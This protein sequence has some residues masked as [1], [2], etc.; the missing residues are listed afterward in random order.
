VAFHGDAFTFRPTHTRVKYFA[1]TQ[2]KR[3]IRQL[4][5]VVLRY[6]YL[7]TDCFSSAPTRSHLCAME[8]YLL[9]LLLHFIFNR[10]QRPLN[11]PTVYIYI[12]IYIRNMFS[13]QTRPA[14]RIGKS[15]PCVQTKRNKWPGIGFGITVQKV[16]H[17]RHPVAYSINSVLGDGPEVAYYL[18][19]PCFSSTFFIFLILC[20][21]KNQSAKT[22]FSNLIRL[23]FLLS[24]LLLNICVS[25]F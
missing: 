5:N 21:K 9:L 24:L 18:P 10:G 14:Q 17:M 7:L 11:A 3:A 20:D 12:Y 8:R 1:G 16:Y 13:F 2:C 6:L 22:Y 25:L 4:T 15:A 23:F 19:C